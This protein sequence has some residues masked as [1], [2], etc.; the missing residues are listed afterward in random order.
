[1]RKL[2]LIGIVYLFAVQ[3]NAQRVT[4]FTDVQVNEVETL[5]TETITI[6]SGASD[7]TIDLLCTEDGGTTDGSIFVQGRNG[8]SGNWLTLGRASFTQIW[9][10]NADSLFTMTDGAIFHLSLTPAVHRQYRVGVTGTASDT[11]TVSGA[12]YLNRY[13]R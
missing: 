10:A 12:Y 5:Y 8:T 11:T 3:A 13:I 4:A 6:S 2:I 9:N 7:L 1:M